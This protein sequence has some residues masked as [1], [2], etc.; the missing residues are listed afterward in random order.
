MGRVR[1]GS[2]APTLGRAACRRPAV[3][4]T[5]PGPAPAAGASVRPSRPRR[6]RPA[7]GARRFRGSARRPPAR[8]P[9]HEGC[10]GIP[11][12]VAR[13]GRAAALLLFVSPLHGSAVGARGGRLAALAA[14]RASSRGGRARGPRGF[15]TSLATPEDGPGGGSARPGGA[16]AIA[17]A[18]AR[19]VPA[20]G[21]SGGARLRQLLLRGLRLAV[22]VGSLRRSSARCAGR[23]VAVARRAP[24]RSLVR[25]AAGRSRLPARARGPAARAAAAGRVA[26]R[27]TGPGDPGSASL[28]AHVVGRPVPAGAVSRADAAVSRRCAGAAA[29]AESRRPVAMATGPWADRCD[30][31]RPG[32]RGPVCA[33]A[34][35]S[36][37][38][39]DSALGR[40]LRTARP[41]ET[42]CPRSR[43]PPRET[44]GLR[45]SGSVR[46]AC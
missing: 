13:P 23:D 22:A 39:P 45:S 14:R 10:R 43:T 28:V 46:S 26:P 8:L 21:G 38:P 15:G 40:P 29:H 31:R 42:T 12:S 9:A 18:G 30:P 41:S 3:P 5:Q 27:A 17:R 34:A 44:H 33:A 1:P 4:G 20:R 16:R 19:R 36:G 35:E 7:D 2:A 25:P 32:G 37:K 11:R 24:A 6:V